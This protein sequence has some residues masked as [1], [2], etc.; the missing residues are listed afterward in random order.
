M[1]RVEGNALLTP[2]RPRPLGLPR[3]HYL[4]CTLQTSPQSILRRV[5]I[6][7]AVLVDQE[8]LGRQQV[9][10]VRLGPLFGVGLKDQVGDFLNGSV[11]DG[12]QSL[13]F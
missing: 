8:G 4:V 7:L 11:D 3:T 9:L 12:G 5:G 6:I 1:H 10:L 2:Y 13:Y